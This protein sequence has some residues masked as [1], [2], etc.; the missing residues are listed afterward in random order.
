MTDREIIENIL[1]QK[2]N[3]LKNHLIEYTQLLEFASY[4]KNKKIHLCPG[5]EKELD[6]NNFSRLI[7]NT[8]IRLHYL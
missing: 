4:D 5:A 1:E 3:V 6:F 2:G 7:Y 8:A